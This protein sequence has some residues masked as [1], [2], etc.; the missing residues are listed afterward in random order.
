[1]FTTA[2]KS[3][4]IS[5]FGPNRIGATVKCGISILVPAYLLV[6]TADQS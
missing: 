2:R 3:F 1:M 5:L 4:M 6:F